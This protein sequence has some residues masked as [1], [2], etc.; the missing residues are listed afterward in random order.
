MIVLAAALAVL[1]L[2][3]LWRPPPR[4][5]PTTAR[6]VDASWLRQG[7][8]LWAGLAASLGPVV[9]G[10]WVGWLLG[11]GVGVGVH[12]WSGRAEPAQV[13][14]DREAVR[15]DL[16]GLVLLLSASLRSGADPA[17]AVRA[18]ARAL[19]GPGA[20]LLAEA[21][22]ELDLG[23]HPAEVWRGLTR[24]PELAPLGRALTRATESGI[25]VAD[26][27]GRLSLELADRSRAEAEDR[28]RRVGV[29]AAVPLGVCLL[30]AFLLLGIVPT[31]V[32]LA[33][34]IRW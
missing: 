23:R 14:R 13:R 32:S 10:G 24:H 18:V 27:V 2:S 22:R 25:S 26:T 34:A 17:T 20:D 21:G 7:R 33:A 9:L 12:H 3:L 19:P 16:P 30:P 28:A 4:S 29:R 8:L 15:R 5:T 31:V 11:V 1:A 6:S